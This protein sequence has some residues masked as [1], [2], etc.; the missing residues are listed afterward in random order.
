MAKAYEAVWNPQW[1]CDMHVER[2]LYE[3]MAAAGYQ[4]WHTGGGCMAWYKPLTEDESEYLMITSESELGDHA[5]EDAK[6][7]HPIFVE[8][9]DYIVGRYHWADAGMGDG[10]WCVWDKPMGAAEAIAMGE[11]LPRPATD[12]ERIIA[13]AG[14]LLP[15]VK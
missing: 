15:E 8:A 7:G 9:S 13:D 1:G 5:G 6:S 14:E 10:G 4:T 3:R 2:S 12:E 11:R